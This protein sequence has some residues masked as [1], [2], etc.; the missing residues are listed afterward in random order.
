MRCPRCQAENREGARFC[1]ECGTRF[2]VVCQSCGAK[3]EPGSK[4]CDICGRSIPPPEPPSTVPSRFASPE[5]YTPKH[6]A[7][8]ILTSRSALEGERKQVTVLFADLKGSM[9]LLAERDPEEARKLLDPVV[10]R[11]IEAVHRYEGTV[12][13]VMGDGIMALFGAPIAHEDHALRACY[14]ALY[15]QESVGR[16][17]GEIRRSEGIPIQVRVGV[18]SGEVVVRSIGSDL[19]MD[20]TA[21][22]QTTHLAARMEQ[23]AT[24]GSILMSSETLRL[25]EGYVQIKP[26]GLMRV[27]GFGE[28]LEVFEAVAAGS[29]RSRLQHAAASG[30]LTRFVGRQK[31]FEALH[32]AL[33]KTQAGHGQV[34][35]IVGEP[36]VGKSRLFWEVTH[37]YRTE[38][39]LVLESRSVSYGKATAYLPVIDLLKAYFRIESHEEKRTALEKVTGKLLTLDKALEPALPAFLALLDVPLEDPAWQ[40]LDPA[41][42]RQRTLEAIKRLLL[43][44]SQVQPLCVIF[45]DL[46]WIDTET[47]ALLDTLIDS[48]P[49]ARL[50]LLVNYRPEYRH[51]W[52]GKTFY[53]QLRLDPLPPENAEELL[54][55]LLGGWTGLQSLKQFL[56]TR[57]EGNPFFLEESVRTLI[58]SQVLVGERGAYRLA[59]PPSSIQVPATV[60]AVLAARI[61]R[62]PIEEKH[63]LQS[64]SVIGTDVPFPLLHAIAELPEDGLRRDLASLQAAEF[65]YE[66]SLFPE[67]E[68]SFR[69]ALTH[70]VAYGGMLQERRGALHA[71]VV[72]AIERLYPE[73]LDEHAERLAHHAFLGEVWD[74]ALLYLRQAGAKSAARSAHR[75]AVAYFERALEALGQL[76]ESRGR[77]EQAVDLRFDLRNSLFALG[78]HARI[79]DRLREAETIAGSLEDQRRAGWVACYMAHCLRMMGEHHRAIDSG[80]R[81]LAGATALGDFALQV[82]ADC[83]LGQAFYLLG[84]YRQAIEHLERGVASLEDGLRHERFGL[85]TL[86]SVFS[87]TWLAWSHAELGEFSDGVVWVEEAARIAEAA[88]HPYSI[89]IASYGM[90]GLY[91][92]MGNLFKAIAALERGLDLCQGGRLLTLFVVTGIHLGYAYALAG[93]SAEALPLLDQAVEQAGASRLD[94]WHSLGVAWLGDAYRLAGRLEEAHHRIRQALEVFRLRGE[95]GYEAWALRGLAELHTRGDSPDLQRAEDFYRQAMS[96]AEELGMRPLVARCHLGLGILYREMGRLPQVQGELSPAIDSFRSMGMTFWLAQAEAELARMR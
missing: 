61:D 91:L 68:Y 53:T 35:A 36:G 48:L 12:N 4:F 94:A 8:K 67:L 57:C 86:P 20:Y 22:G 41:R 51:N 52:G 59:K 21:V 18:N 87:R 79:H 71:L 15:M 2:D 19:H 5:S 37:S 44:E 43:R 14:A 25:V 50:L 74:K 28:P 13:Q 6:I 3:V 7:E 38:G 55:V 84:S 92:R 93:R 40:V 77:M 49:G 1:R 63:L 83:Y 62:L 30:S 82:E 11:M 73:R 81:A 42:R 47:Q 32:Q 34:V 60:Q 26:L 65:L 17:A 46:Q 69:H 85:P 66:R 78:D 16:Y 24:P 75:E 64:A 56:I 80:R 10:E 90:G 58:E 70:Q 45:E 88:D 29:V 72:Q 31:E 76:P 27:K 96:L 33:E 89:G 54:Q 95:R 9:E 39:W 23:L